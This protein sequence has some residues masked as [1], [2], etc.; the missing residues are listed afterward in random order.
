MKR[1]T[2]QSLLLI[3]F[4]VLSISVNAQIQSVAGGGTWDETTT[5]VGGVVPGENNDVIING[6]VILNGTYT[7]RNLTVSSSGVLQN[8]YGHSPYLTVQGNIVNNG[9]IRN[10]PDGYHLR[11]YCK[12]NVTN[13]GE[14]SNLWLA[15]NSE[16]NQYIGGTSIYQ[17]NEIYKEPNG[18]ITASSDLLVGDECTFNLSYDV[19]Y[20]QSYK[21]TA[22]SPESDYFYGGTVHSNGEIDVTG[23]WGSNLD[24]NYTLVGSNPMNFRSTNTSFGDFTVAPGKVIQNRYGHSPYL[25]V[26][27]NI[28]NNG[29]IRDNPDGY[30]LRIYCKGNVTNNGEFSNMWLT[31][32]S[33]N[34]QY[35]NGTSTYQIEDIY[36]DPNG[37]VTATS[38]L[39]FGDN[40][41]F[42]LS[43]D[44]LYMQSYKLTANSPESDYFYGGTVHSNGEIDVTGSWGSNLDG[45]YTLVGSNPMNFRST[46]TSFGDFTV[47][48][49]KVIQNRYGHSPYLTVQGNIVNNGTIRDNPDGYNLRIYCK[50]NVTNNGEFSNMWLTLNSENNQYINGTSTYQIEDIYKEPNGY[51]TAS[52][53]LLFGDKCTFNLSYDTLYMQSYKL[54]ANSPGSHYFYNGT[55]HSNGE[56]DVTGTWGSNL[57]G[58]VTL[59]G[60]DTMRIGPTISS[61]GDLTV[62]SEKVVAN[63][64]GSSPYFY[65]NNLTNYGE[66]IDNPDGYHLRAFINGD[67]YN[68]GEYTIYYTNFYADGKHNKI[69]GEVFSDIYIY[70]TDDPDGGSFTIENNFTSNNSLRIYEEANLNILSGASLNCKNYF[71]NSGEI[72]NKGRLSYTFRRTYNGS[73]SLNKDFNLD[74]YLSDRAEADTFTVAV[75]NS[76]YPYLTSSI[77]RWW[78]FDANKEGGTYSLTLYYEDNLLNGQNEDQLEVFLTPDNGETWQKL[79]NPINKTIDKEANTIT[80][81]TSSEPL[82][83]GY[84]DIVISSGNITQVPQIGL[85]VVGRRDVR[86]GPPNRYSVSYWNNSNFPTDE[87]FI[88]LNTNR[89]VHIM[90]VITTDIET[91]ESVEIPI[92]SLT[93]ANI[94]D[95]AFLLINGL[96]PDELRTFEVILGAVPDEETLSKAKIEPITLTVAA[97]W[98]GG[99]LLKDY[100]G[101]VVV[102]GCYEMWRPVKHDQSLMDAS[103]NGLTSSMKKA[104][105]FENGGK[106]LAKEAAEQVVKR[107]G[108]A[109]LWPA[110]LAMDV[111]DCMKNTVKG[112]KDYVNGNFDKKEK[113]L[114]KVTSWDPNAK[115][116]PTGFGENGYM[117]STDPMN[118]TILFENKK[119]ATA[120]AW[121]VVILDTLDENV[122]DISSVKVGKMSHDMGVFSQEGNI[123]KWEFVEIELQPNVTPPEGEGFVRFTVDL[124]PNLPNGTE[125]KNKAEIVFDLNK[126]IMTNVALNTLD[127]ES[128]V[129]EVGN[130]EFDG[131][132][133]TISW[134]VNDQNGSGGKETKVYLSK[135]DAPFTLAGKSF[136]NS[137][138]VPVE[139]E[140]PYKLYLVTQDNVG[141]IEK[142]PK[143]VEKVFSGTE[144]ENIVPDSYSLEQN[145]PNPF[146]PTTTIVYDLP[147]VSQIKLGIYNVLGERIALLE[148]GIRSTGRHYV[149][150]DGSKLSSGVYFY[151]IEAKAVSGGKDFSAV[152]KLLLLK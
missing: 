94:N 16:S 148:D 107:T 48:P 10:N 61:F 128:P 135:N 142:E 3:V 83:Y 28:V 63:R 26:Q 72:N 150:F 32:N 29:T 11:I 86:V 67:F 141:N 117:S 25:T 87:F 24:G 136:T 81:G 7:I 69:S 95:E 92:D 50:G 27:G 123:L 38:D 6:T 78:S 13:N 124:L 144:D 98:L 100:V 104:A 76:V 131:D 93:Y 146:N 114:R 152:K 99:A 132:L 120:P 82:D 74:F 46:N 149:T 42:N 35:I 64:Y 105:T 96:E 139:A 15:L 79:S 1:K 90:S 89:G 127:F 97:V 151:R 145:Y 73:V 75:N 88:E 80:V 31:L 18:D 51:I 101:N 140:V 37:Y 84:G 66:I 129:T 106:T 130:M 62:S 2:C 14:F 118:Y 122:Y 143:V 5:W 30:N 65:I 71:S 115:E 125:I 23:S 85:S 91:G 137:V 43:Y 36:K 52:S 58:N 22:N 54:T 110:F 45:N 103:I 44:T 109:A 21:L 113:E 134:S 39:V 33:E 47:A 8:R 68:Y 9:T 59:V 19:L 17:I 119:E 121:K 111:Y 112:M 34:N 133:A 60:S 102:E 4:L 41:T 56:I 116:G 55:V 57:D 53:D 147:V 138:Q 49:G 70:K 20:M 108:K 40:C 77:N 12:G 126:P